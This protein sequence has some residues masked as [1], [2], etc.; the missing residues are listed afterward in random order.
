MTIMTL[1]SLC[2]CATLSGVMF[3]MMPWKGYLNDE[4]LILVARYSDTLVM[5][6][7]KANIKTYKFIS[8]NSDVKLT[9]TSSKEIKDLKRCFIDNI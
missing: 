7:C 1:I 2:G 4:G 8:S 9:S 5:G 6:Q 3:S